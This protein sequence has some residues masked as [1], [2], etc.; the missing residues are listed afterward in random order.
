MLYVLR[1]ILLAM[2]WEFER[3]IFIEYG[4]NYSTRFTELM[5]DGPW[6]RAYCLVNG[7]T[8]GTSTLLVDVTIIWHCWV[9]W[10]HQWR[11]VLLPIICAIAGT[12]MK[13]MQILSYFPNSTDDIS[14]TGGSVHYFIDW[15]SIYALLTLVTTLMCTVLIVY[16]I[17]RFAHR[18][19]V[20]R[21]ILSALI[22]SSTIYMLALIV[23]LVL[24]GRNMIAVY[25]TDIIASYVKA[26]ALTLLVLRV[27]ARSNS[28]SSNE[29][30]NASRDLSVICFQRMDENSCDDIGESSV[31]GSHYRTSDPM[32]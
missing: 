24:V 20:F 23:Y 3:C 27:V 26:I 6:G 5:D 29:E 10:D 1:T 7:I 4:E 11:I 19:L 13:T 2:D 14:N 28:G 18:L 17:I 12:I 22:E 31:P 16:R 25:Y 32:L 9:L 21:G 8:G 15:V 30:H